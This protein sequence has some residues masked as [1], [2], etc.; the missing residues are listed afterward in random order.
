[1]STN[2]I[3]ARAT[4]EATFAGVYHH[5]D[6]YPNG[7]LGQQLTDLLAGHFAGDLAVMLRTLIDEHPAGW[8][9]IVSKDF[10][11]EPG[12]TWEKLDHPSL[13]GVDKDKYKAAYRAY[14][15]HPDVLRPQCYCHGLRHEQ[16][17]VITEQSDCGAEWAYV[18]EE[19]DR[20]M[21]VLYRDRR[22]GTGERFWNDVARIELDKASEVNW[23]HVECG[24]EYERCGHYAWAHIPEMKG[25]NLGMQTFLGRQ[26]F[27]MHDA[28]AFIVDGKRYVNSGSGGDSGFVSRTRPNGKRWPEGLWLAAVVAGNGKRLEVPVAYRTAEGFRPYRGVQWV[29][30]PTLKT[31]RETIIGEATQ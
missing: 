26:P 15:A 2:G 25:S 22:E 16:P 19:Q 20:A 1:M 8:S 11:L 7:G 5:W 17:H 31:P 14:H 27:D 3:I 13:L 30:P 9:T 21:H 6:S 23:T 28:V 10:T 24:E 12:Y 4:G 29:M 18:F